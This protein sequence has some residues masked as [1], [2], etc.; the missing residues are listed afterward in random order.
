MGSRSIRGL[1]VSQGELGLL[2]VVLY[3]C[4]ICAV[5][6]IMSSQG[7]AHLLMMNAGVP[8]RASSSEAEDVW[9]RSLCVHA[10]VGLSVVKKCFAQDAGSVRVGSL[11]GIWSRQRHWS[12]RDWFQFLPRTQ[13]QHQW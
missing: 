11:R 6:A 1:Q 12:I 4:V 2:N 7:A 8:G 9:T 3:R 5:I 10:I 13:H